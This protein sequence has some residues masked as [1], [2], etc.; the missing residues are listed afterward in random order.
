M[1][2]QIPAPVMLYLLT[3]EMLPLLDQTNASATLIKSVRTIEN[4][5]AA[6][7]KKIESNEDLATYVHDTLSPEFSRIIESIEI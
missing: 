7:C 4:F 6:T 3:L 2:Q 1:S 5:A